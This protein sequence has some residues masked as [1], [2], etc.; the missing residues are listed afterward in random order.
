MFKNNVNCDWIEY[1]SF[2]MLF[3]SVISR[4]VHWKNVTVSKSSAWGIAK[5]RIQVLWTVW[6]Q[7]HWASWPSLELSEPHIL[8]LSAG[9]R[10]VKPQHSLNGL[11][12][13]VLCQVTIMTTR[14]TFNWCKESGSIEKGGGTLWLRTWVSIKLHISHSV[15]AEMFLEV[16]DHA[17]VH[18][19]IRPR[20]LIL[21]WPWPFAATSRAT[22]ERELRSLF[23]RSLPAGEDNAAIRTGCCGRF[24]GCY[25]NNGRTGEG[26]RACSCTPSKYKST[27]IS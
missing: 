27:C 17:M 16:L 12:G 23:Y 13:T 4:I 19:A 9:L 25:R 2:H 21:I 3:I 6:V 10:S 26:S 5:H 15:L 11:G 22:L 24:A 18:V 8:F 20:W 7:I 1:F 14:K